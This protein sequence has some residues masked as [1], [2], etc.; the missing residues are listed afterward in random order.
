MVEHGSGSASNY[1]L[2]VHRVFNIKTDDLVLM[3]SA[4]VSKCV[5]WPTQSQAKQIG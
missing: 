4:I 3:R 5:Q 1:K 2:V